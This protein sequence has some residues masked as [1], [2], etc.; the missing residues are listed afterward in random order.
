MTTQN[1]WDPAKAVLR[2]KFIAIQ[3]SSRKITNKQHN[4]TPKATRERRTKPK[5]RRR[6]E[7]IN[8]RTEINEREMKETIVNI[9]KNKSWFF[10]KIKLK[11]FS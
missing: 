5:I 10:E 2:G 6:K 4:L 11:T 3:Y 8:I 9:H 1:L 7:I